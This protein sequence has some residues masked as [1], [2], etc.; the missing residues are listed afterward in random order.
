MG[1]DAWEMQEEAPKLAGNVNLHIPSRQTTLA[2]AVQEQW[3]TVG[4][5]C[6][7][8]MKVSLPGNKIFVILFQENFSVIFIC[9]KKLC[10]KAWPFS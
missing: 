5:K 1:S 9:K 6:T 3:D 2:V 8:T 7:Q 10:K 4:E